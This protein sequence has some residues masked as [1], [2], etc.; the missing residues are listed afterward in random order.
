MCHSI[1][2][3]SRDSPNDLRPSE[4]TKAPP[5]PPIKNSIIWGAMWKDGAGSWWTPFDNMMI[6]VGKTDFNDILKTVRALAGEGGEVGGKALAL[7]ESWKQLVTRHHIHRHNITIR[8]WWWL[9]VTLIATITIRMRWWHHIYCHH[10]INC[11]N[12]IYCR[13]HIHSHRCVC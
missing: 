2:W 7:L 4:F 13:R 10:H 9:T 11:H 8:M 5:P 6:I 1:G 3:T 12:H